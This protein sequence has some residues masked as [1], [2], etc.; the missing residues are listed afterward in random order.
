MNAAL[1]GGHLALGVS[2]AEEIA[3]LIDSGDIVPMVAMIEKRLSAYPN[4]PCTKELGIESF[5]GPWRAMYA[6][7]GAPQAACDSFAAAVEKAMQDP[8]YQDFM[9]KAGYLDRT[10]YATGAETLA[11][12]SS[13]NPIFENY[14]KAIGII[15]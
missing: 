5:I 13:E 12:Q 11:L 7:T 1:V 2:G 6:R 4:I 15:K 10:A 9:Q 8:S 14:L 3:G